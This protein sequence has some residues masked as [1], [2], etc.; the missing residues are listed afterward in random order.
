MKVMIAEDEKLATE[1][2]LTLLNRYDPDIEVV[3]CPESVEETVHYLKHH[4]HPDLLLL[5]IQLSDGLSFEIFRQV[6]FT[7]PVIFT[8]AYDQY[9]LDAFRLLSVD[10]ILKPVTQETLAAA[11]NKFRSWSQLFSPP[12]LNK[13][14]PV[15][16]VVRYKKRFLGKVGQRL[17]FINADRIAFFQADN[18]IVYLVDK[19]GNRY[20]VDA[21]MEQLSDLL[22][23]RQFFRLNRRFIVSVEAILQVKPY[24]NGRL[25]LTVMGYGATDDVVVSRDRVP[26]FKTWAETSSYTI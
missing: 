13:L 17:F 16:P 8:T 26:E 20:V 15:L 1:R 7:R 14:S 2:L 19:E 4:P 9:A 3:A 10:Y 5:D 22:D 11:I 6:N 21:T 25:K 12:D 24:Y 23:P 18:K